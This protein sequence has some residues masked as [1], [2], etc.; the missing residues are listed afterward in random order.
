MKSHP[1]CG[2]FVA[3]W[4]LFV[5]SASASTLE[6]TAVIDWNSLEISV[7]GEGF[8]T[9]LDEHVVFNQAF[10]TGP[11]GISNSGSQSLFAPALAASPAPGDTFAIAAFDGGAATA[12][13]GA[14]VGIAGAASSSRHMFAAHGA[15]TALISV[16]YGLHVESGQALGPAAAEVALKATTINFDLGP[17]GSG[18]SETANILSFGP[19][20]ELVDAGTL[21]LAI[22]FA[23]SGFQLIAIEGIA[24][25][26]TTGFTIDALGGGATAVPIPAGL[27]L[28]LSALTA[29]GVIG[30]RK[31]H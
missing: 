17:F 30:R 31:S 26:F 13:A 27:P 7:A 14:D 25:A 8:L 5:G 16:N 23:A 9:P 18:S 21:A 6:A 29:L 28:L 4:T 10:T 20:T 22:D 11:F 19:I 15:G 1:L 2:V 3:C 24:S 12:H